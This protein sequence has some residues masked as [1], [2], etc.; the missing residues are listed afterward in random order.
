[1]LLDALYPGYVDDVGRLAPADAPE[2]VQ[3]MQL[4]SGDNAER[5]DMVSGL[6]Q[7]TSPAAPPMIPVIVVTHGAGHAPPCQEDGRAADFPVA[8]L[9]AA[10]QAGQAD[11][12]ESL[13]G[14]LIVAE[15]TGH[16]IADENPGLALGLTAEVIA[17]VGEP[18]NLAMPAAS[19][20]A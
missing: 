4:L 15:G 10:W 16:A 5:L 9:E 19:P 14:R 3:Q 11:L 12:A 13:G 7:A 8:E 17:A 2:T 6:R 20:T 1:V 18:G